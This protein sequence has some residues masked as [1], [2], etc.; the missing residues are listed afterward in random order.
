MLPDHVSFVVRRR[1]I[2]TFVK[3]LKFHS[4]RVWFML[5]N[6]G[7]TEV[8]GICHVTNEIDVNSKFLQFFSTLTQFV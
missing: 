2:Y 7:L 1:L 3:S 4:V 8:A 5:V 6:R